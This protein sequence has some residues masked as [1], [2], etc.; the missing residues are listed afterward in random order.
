MRRQLLRWRCKPRRVSGPAG[1]TAL[2]SVNSGGDLGNQSSG[3]AVIAKGGRYIAFQSNATNLVPNDFNMT[4]DVFV[5]DRKLNTVERVSVASDGTEGN[6]NSFG[7]AISRDGRYVAFTSHASNLVDND[8]NG[9]S[10]AF[11]H[12]RVT[13]E[14]SLV[15]VGLSGES[16][17]S[18]TAF[19][20]D[21][22]ADGRYVAFASL[23]DNLTNDPKSPRME[24]YVRDLQLGLTQRATVSATGGKADRSHVRLPSISD[25]GRYVAFESLATNLASG[26]SNRN[27]DVYVRDLQARTTTLVSRGLNGRAGRGGNSWRPAISGNG[28]HVA[29]QSDAKNLVRDDS[30]GVSDVFLY[31]MGTQSTRRISLRPNGQQAGQPSDGP[32]ISV[33]GRYIAFTSAAVLA[34]DFPATSLRAYLWDRSTKDNELVSVANDGTPASNAVAAEDVS[35]HGQ[36]VVFSGNGGNLLPKPG[37]PQ[38]QTFLRIRSP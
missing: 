20:L 11:V 19:G 5:R 25:D 27:L 33:N 4:N 7:T 38:A 2:V 29:Y 30:N 35:P 10:D 36:F 16:G 28:R 9:T 24:I 13:G 3:D 21:I 8:S 18:P 22:S 32:S 26:D 1:D 15:S 23:A 12:D 31:N 14:T 34:G 6:S 37:D 17:D